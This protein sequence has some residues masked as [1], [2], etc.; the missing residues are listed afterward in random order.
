MK[1]KIHFT[2]S[3]FDLQAIYLPF[4]FIR[5]KFKAKPLIYK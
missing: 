4:E 2:Y 5:F 3:E 1:L